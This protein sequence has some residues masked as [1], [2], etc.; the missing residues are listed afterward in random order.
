MTTPTRPYYNIYG[1]EAG[2][3]HTCT[4]CGTE[5]HQPHETAGFDC[6]NGFAWT[7]VCHDCHRKAVDRMKARIQKFIDRPVEIDFAPSD[8]DELL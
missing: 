2:T 4:V 7:L 8:L 5:R 3:I 1:M 6:A